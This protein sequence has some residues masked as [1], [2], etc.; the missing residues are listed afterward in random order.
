MRFLGYF[1]DRDKNRIEQGK[2]RLLGTF[3][4]I[5]HFCIDNNVDQIYVCI[6]VSQQPRIINLLNELKDTTA[7][8]YVVPDIFVTD[9]VQGSLNHINGIPVVAICESP[10]VGFR[11]GIKRLFDILISFL[12]LLVFSPVLAWVVYKIKQTSPGP[13][14]FIQK[15]YGLDGKSFEIYKF[16][17]MSVTENGDNVY[18]QVVE[19]DNRVT[20]FGAF[21][22]KTSLDEFPQF[23]NVLQGRMSLVGPRPHVIAVNENYR[24]LI[25]GYMI[26]HKVKPGSTGWA[27]VNGY[28]GG[29][30]LE[31]MLG[32]IE[33]DLEY[34]RKWSLTLDFLILF[35][36]FFL[37][38]MGDKKAF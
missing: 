16:R 19:N 33:Y 37:L 25:P 10:L 20:S 7:S 11:A 5:E 23:F 30:D 28:R 6:P 1:D 4:D 26:R 35:R 15:R 14:I 34:L 18:K 9:L 17:T 29:D 27:Q 36:T 8:I 32:R 2:D 22:R 12:V 24:K 21:L 13:V 3:S 38:A 31:H